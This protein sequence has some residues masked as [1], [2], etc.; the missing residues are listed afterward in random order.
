MVQT[1]DAVITVVLE[2]LPQAEVS[3][4]LK[5]RDDNERWR[6]SPR[7]VLAAIR[8]SLASVIAGRLQRHLRRRLQGYDLLPL[9]LAGPSCALYGHRL[10]LVVIWSIIGS[11]G[12]HR[13][14]F[15]F[16]YLIFF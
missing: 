15:L 9:L 10:R 3:Y 5:Y 16:I 2:V 12:V 14:L 4:V 7:A 6:Y 1:S 13:L 11:T 8:S